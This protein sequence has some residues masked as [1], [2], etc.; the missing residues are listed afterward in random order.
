MVNKYNIITNQSGIFHI[1]LYVPTGSIHEKP[2]QS[3]CSH[4][5][6]HMLFKNKGE[7]SK[8]LSKVLTN[9]GARYNAATYKDTTY[10]YIK[11]HSSFYKD[12]ID[13]MQQLTTNANFT[14]E[15]LRVERKVIIEEYNQTADSFSRYLF[16]LSNNSIMHKDNVYSKSV[17]GH[18]KV[19]SNISAAELKQY[20]KER[21]KEMVVVINC[22]ENIK[23]RVERYVNGKFGPNTDY[24][25]CNEELLKSASM[26]E[27]KL[28]FIN[29]QSAQYMT[30]LSFMTFPAE[31]IKDH[32]ILSFIQYCLT[33][34]G[35]YSILNHQL[36]MIRG[37]V[38]GVSS[39]SEIL[40]YT[41]FYYIQLGSSSSKTD[42][43]VSLLLHNIVKLKIKGLSMKQL[44]YY[45]K[46]YLSFVKLSLLDQDF[47]TEYHGSSLI[48]NTYTSDDKLLKILGKITNDDIRNV[49]KK[50]FDFDKLGIISIGGYPNVDAMSKRVQDIVNSY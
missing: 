36:R 42:Y 41:G 5:L 6:E 22:D 50:A 19:L 23:D 31:N 20:Y 17:I 29:K 45:K 18:I 13:I 16:S 34:S 46:S 44:N 1:Y 7:R 15:E 2:K 33:G 27:P 10:Y 26:I 21:Y 24:T 25:F 14:E 38:Y 3:G 30:K 8:D 35:L 49:S 37:L 28:I 39:F 4:M 32:I 43:I 9:I 48:Y 11:T 40:M 47:R 12:A